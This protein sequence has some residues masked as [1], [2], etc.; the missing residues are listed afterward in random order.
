MDLSNTSKKSGNFQFS[1]FQLIDSNKCVYNELLDMTYTMWRQEKG[2]GSRSDDYFPGEIRQDAAA[3]RVSP[4]AK[5]FTLKWN[6]KTIK[7]WL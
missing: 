7:L 4:T 3:F 2:F 6:G 5:D 1:Q